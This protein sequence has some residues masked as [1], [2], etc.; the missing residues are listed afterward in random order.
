L[1]AWQSPP[2]GWPRRREEREAPRRC[3]RGDTRTRRGRWKQHWVICSSSA[4]RDLF[5]DAHAVELRAPAPRVYAQRVRR[6]RREQL[7]SQ[8]R[9]VH[10]TS[11]AAAA[12]AGP[13][14]DPAPRELGAGVDR[15]RIHTG[16]CIAIHTY[17]VM[18]YTMPPTRER[19]EISDMRIGRV[20]DVTCPRAS[21]WSVVSS[22]RRTASLHFILTTTAIAMHH[23]HVIHHSTSHC[24]HH[25][26]AAERDNVL[27]ALQA[28]LDV[29]RTGEAVPRR[30]RSGLSAPECCHAR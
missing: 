29:E 14:R 10:R 7:E 21:V 28:S 2:R 18:P 9:R 15:P 30:H 5:Q 17:H 16:F 25:P 11:G 6:E 20:S 12:Q 26:R 19:R 13:P 23:E 22:D 4:Q 3:R 8:R 1:A 27:R 24:F